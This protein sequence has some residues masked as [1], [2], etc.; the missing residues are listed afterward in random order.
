MENPFCGLEQG[1]T[2]ETEPPGR[3]DFLSLRQR[4]FLS[5]Q[6]NKLW[7]RSCITPQDGVLLE[8]ATERFGGLKPD[9][10]DKK[11][12]LAWPLVGRVLTD[13]LDEAKA[14]TAQFFGQ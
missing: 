13:T 5:I 14:A 10:K 6:Q 8:P 2:V 11:T 1:H 12:V 9:S 3:N 4:A 7:N